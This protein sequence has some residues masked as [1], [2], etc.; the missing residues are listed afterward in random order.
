[1]KYNIPI[2]RL[3]GV[4][5]AL[6]VLHHSLLAYHPFAPPPPV[7]LLGPSP[8][9]QA[10]PVVDAQRTAL[11]SL[12]VGF[13][14]VFFMSLMFFV[15]GL[16]VWP[17][18]RRKGGARFLR[19]RLVRLGLPFLAAAAIVA[20]LAYYP[21]YLQTASHDGLAGFAK[22]WLSLGVWPAGP[23]WFI[24]VLLVF[25]AA[26]V[27]LFAAWPKWGETLE[28][29]AAPRTPIVFFGLLA[30]VSAAVYVPMALTFTPIAWA[31]FGPFAFQTSRILH[32]FVYFVFGI[33]VGAAGLDH[34]VLAQDGKLARRWPLWSVT[35]LL[36]FAAVTVVTIV[37]LTS[38]AAS[39]GWAVAM[40]VGFVLSC[41]ASSFAFLA[42]FLRFAR[43]PSRVFDSLSA[44]SYTIYL[45]HYA[46]VSWMQYALLPA[47]IPGA[48]K[49]VTAFAGA[50]ALSWVTA[51]AMRRVPALMR[52]PA[53]AAAVVAE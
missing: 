22:Q 53:S 44:N 42:L 37:G 33:G 6:V 12:I 23:A 49:G 50:L 30:V 9:W 46:F 14:D 18:L 10:F 27:L 11:S 38:H 31:S 5:V 1:M 3:R 21:T 32:Y 36:M 4:L 26:A 7:S 24:W 28:R 41:A 8:W 51:A 20:P 15:S 45:V 17:G 13:N 43:S 48:V 16:F 25:D 35:A 19:D 29:L 34:G 47:S 52:G 40:D 39:R 2:A